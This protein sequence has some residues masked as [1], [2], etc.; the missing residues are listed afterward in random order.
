MIVELA[1]KLSDKALFEVNYQAST[2]E[3]RKQID[4]HP[5]QPRPG[6]GREARRSLFFMVVDPPIRRR[7]IGWISKRGMCTNGERLEFFFGTSLFTFSL[8]LVV[9]TDA[10]P[11]KDRPL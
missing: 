9:Q 2:L 3:L 8:Q 10:L 1:C 4:W 5:S 6:G 7:R 11:H